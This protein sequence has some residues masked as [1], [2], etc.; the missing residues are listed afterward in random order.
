MLVGKDGR[1]RTKDK[2]KKI[3]KRDSLH[4]VMDQRRSIIKNFDRDDQR[5]IEKSAKFEIHLDQV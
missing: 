1:L 2:L 4:V 3:K 5:L